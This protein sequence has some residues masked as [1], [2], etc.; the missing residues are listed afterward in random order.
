CFITSSLLNVHQRIHTGEEPYK[1]G[2]CGEKFR[3]RYGLI[4]HQRMH[5]GEWPY[6]CGECGK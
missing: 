6:K 1:C 2:E 4:R 5:A 3:E